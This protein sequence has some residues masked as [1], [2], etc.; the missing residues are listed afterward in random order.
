M[1]AD[2]RKQITPNACDSRTLNLFGDDLPFQ[3]DCELAQ[4]DELIAVV[5]L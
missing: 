5:L 3:F 4:F 1:C 2:M